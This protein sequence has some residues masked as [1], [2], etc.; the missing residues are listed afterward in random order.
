M[1]HAMGVG[2]VST[3]E[4]QKGVK[5]ELKH[6]AGVL[7][8]MEARVAKE[9]HLRRHPRFI[10]QLSSLKE[11]H[12]VLIAYCYYVIWTYVESQLLSEDY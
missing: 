1:M 5:R 6:V 4:D 2:I 3:I 9:E 11:A 8:D 10:A 12:K 7:N